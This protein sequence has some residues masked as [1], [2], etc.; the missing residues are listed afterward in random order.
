MSR[1]KISKKGENGEKDEKVC[2][3]GMTACKTRCFSAGKERKGE[4]SLGVKCSIPANRL[5]KK[6]VLFDEIPG[7]AR[8]CKIM[9]LTIGA[10]ALILMA[11]KFHERRITA[12]K[13]V[14]VF[15]YYYY[16][17]MNS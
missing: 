16:F 5:R 7:G 17:T 4:A 11:M 9:R 13:S 6:T 10:E 8:K 1:V 14:F 12:M 2:T 3:F 15:A